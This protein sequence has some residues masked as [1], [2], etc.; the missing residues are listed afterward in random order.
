MSAGDRRS[1]LSWAV[2]IGVQVLGPLC[3][4]ATVWLFAKRGGAQLQG[5]FAQAKAWVDLLVAV[6]CFGFPQSIVYVVNRQGVAAGRLVRPTLLYGAVLFPIAALASFWF[7]PLRG[8]SGML[9]LAAA[10]AILIVHGILRGIVLTLRQDIGFALMSIAPAVGL[11]LFACLG[12]WN[13]LELLFL[14]ASVPA[15]LYGLW[16]VMP[17]LGRPAGADKLPLDAL[18][19]NGLE[20]FLQSVLTVLQPVLAYS[21]IHRFGGGEAD[22]GLLHTGLFLIQG[23]SIPISLLSPLLFARWTSREPSH[24]VRWLLIRWWRW[25]ILGALAGIVLAIAIPPLIP[26]VLGSGYRLAENAVALLMVTLPLAC[27]TR[28]ASPALHASGSPRANTIAAAV[29]LVAMLGAGYAIS[30][31]SGTALVGV[32]AGW[33]LA[34]VCGLLPVWWTMRSLVQG[35]GRRS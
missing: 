25:L 19:S 2:T 3:G 28:L 14:M 29:R 24:V 15:L 11:F 12:H 10:A 32:A 26:L 16:M 4:F 34:E 21:L 23:A 9:L 27:Q 31:L 35:Q 22:V 13:D 18:L 1:R 5:E 30:A 8:E 20:V 33:S 17:L 7:G 6:G